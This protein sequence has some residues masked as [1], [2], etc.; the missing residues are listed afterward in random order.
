MDRKRMELLLQIQELEFVAVELTLFMDTHPEQRQPLA[1]YNQVTERLQSLKQ[2]YEKL[3]GPFMVFGERTTDR[4][5]WIDEPW[6]W[7]M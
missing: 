1:D 7:E 3:Y 2:E 4:W 5:S 6:P